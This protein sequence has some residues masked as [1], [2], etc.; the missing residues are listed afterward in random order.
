MKH[1]IKVILLSAFFM[2]GCARQFQSCNRDVQTGD[3]WYEV[4]QYSG[5]LLVATYTFRG[6][7]NNQQHSDGYYWYIG[8]TLYEVSGTTIVRSW[9]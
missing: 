1:R 2:A 8:D 7:L 3:R 4:K 6:I 9:K 5:P